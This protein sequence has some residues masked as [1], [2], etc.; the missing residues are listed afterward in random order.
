L[1]GKQKVFASSLIARVGMVGVGFLT[2]VAVARLFGAASVGE[3]GL[4]VSFLAVASH[5]TLFGGHMRVLKEVS[6]LHQK[7]AFQKRNGILMAATTAIFVCWVAVALVIVLMLG[8]GLLGGYRSLLGAAAFWL[9]PLAVL[10][11]A[12]RIHFLETFRALQWI[13]VYN[14]LSFAAAAFLLIAV[15]CAGWLGVEEFSISRVM[16][17]LELVGALLAVSVLVAALRPETRFRLASKTAMRDHIR[18]SSMYFLSGSSIL[19]GQVDILLAGQF[20]PIDEVGV[21]TVALRVSSIV[22]IILVAANI[23]FAPQVAERFHTAGMDGAVA[24]A[25]S[26]TRVLFP[27]TVAAALLIIVLSPTILGLFGSGFRDGFS[28]VVILSLG[29]VAATL[30]GQPGFFL[31]MTTGQKDMVVVTVSALI[32][33]LVA[34]LVLIPAFGIIGAALSSSSALFLRALFATYFIKR[35]TGTGITIFHAL[36]KGT[37]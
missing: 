22:C 29:H 8:A 27:I 7:G 12:L 32:F 37:K 24:Y 33:G 23:S 6:P 35:Q 17:A 3:M 36:V 26:Q 9:L 5:F 15:S 16:V 13:G 10:L 18:D 1:S 14:L 2:S 31:Q 25:R 11:N 20:L 19:I 21:Y 4:L 34:G 28:A 30:F